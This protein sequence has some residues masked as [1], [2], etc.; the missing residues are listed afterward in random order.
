[1]RVIGKGEDC[2][3][4]HL[5]VHLLV[6]FSAMLTYIL[7]YVPKA[8]PYIGCIFGFG[9][10]RMPGCLASSPVRSSFI[11]MVGSRRACESCEAVTQ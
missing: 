3:Y 1:M 4:V 6:A 11:L 8:R 9:G 2:L 5:H 7:P 10:R